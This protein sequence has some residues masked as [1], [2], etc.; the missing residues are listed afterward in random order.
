MFY[1]VIEPIDSS[2]EFDSNEFYNRMSDY[3]AL[4]QVDF[5]NPDKAKADLGKLVADDEKFIAGA[6]TEK[7]LGLRN[8]LYGKSEQDLF[9][10]TQKNFKDV[11]GK[12]DDNGLVSLVF[13]IPTEKGVANGND[14]VVEA[15]DKFHK[16][17]KEANEDP[18]KYISSEL[19]KVHK[20][21]REIVARYGASAIIQHSLGSLQS[22]VLKYFSTDKGE[23]TRD[24]AGDFIKAYMDHYSASSEEET[25]MKG[26]AIG[27]GVAK[28]AYQSID[29]E[30]KKQEQAKKMYEQA[31]ENNDKKTGNGK[32]KKGKKN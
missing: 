26:R 15:V 30:N 21:F 11:S 2:K 13:G 22:N 6:D 25:Q 14:K 27:M 32:G 19:D 5:N 17:E 8:A 3:V 7:A 20:D 12:L 18:L 16:A 29:V 1:M 23:F 24:K 31:K 9:N 28:G 4:S 10:Y